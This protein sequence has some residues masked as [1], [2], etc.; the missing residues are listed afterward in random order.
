MMFRIIQQRLDP[1]LR[2]APRARIQRLLLRPDD[3]LGVGVLVEV[4]AELGPG[5]WVKLLDA[6][7]GGFVEFVLGAVFVEGDVDLAAAEDYAVDFFGWG[8]VVG[9][10][11]G[12]SDDPLEV[13]FAGE[14]F[15]GRAGEGVA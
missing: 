10:V 9:L 12:V 4:L 11:G 15:D 14:V 8:D 1:R 5:E 2:E 3:R 6:G 13:G 7:D